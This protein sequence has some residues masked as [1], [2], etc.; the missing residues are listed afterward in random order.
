MLIGAGIGSMT[1][2]RIVGRDSSRWYLAFAGV[3]IAGLI[4]WATYPVLSTYFIAA[5]MPVRIA[6]A[7]AM[8]FPIAFFMGMPFP[9]GV[10]ALRTKPRGAIAWAWSMNGLF[11]TIGSVA[12]VLLSLWLGFRVTVLVALGMYA[13]AGLT[14]RSLR[15]RAARESIGCVAPARP[16]RR[17]RRAA[18]AALW[19]A[20]KRTTGAVP[21]IPGS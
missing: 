9:L 6:A 15:G 17:S 18:V 16:V 12:T 20:R 11:S 19:A 13:L 10:L 5:P 21:F 7:A 2:P 14:F 3:L 4:T 1:S 8:I